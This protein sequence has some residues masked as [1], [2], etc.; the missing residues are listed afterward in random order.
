MFGKALD[1]LRQVVLVM[2][3]VALHAESREDRR[4]A[5]FI[6]RFCSQ[7]CEC[8]RM[9]IA[10]L[11]IYR[12]LATSETSLLSYE[13]LAARVERSR[14]H[15]ELELTHAHMTQLKTALLSESAILNHVM[16]AEYCLSSYAFSLI[17]YGN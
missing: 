4:Q 10:L 3:T 7:L 15:V 13:T 11:S 1:D 9:R 6:S 8:A 17:S 16:T 14:S 2:N 12:A 5:K